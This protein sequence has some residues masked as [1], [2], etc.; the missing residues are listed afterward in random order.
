MLLNRRRQR[1]PDACLS[2]RRDGRRIDVEQ[3]KK[4]TLVALRHED[5]ARLFTLIGRSEFK[6]E[7]VQEMID[8][9]MPTNEDGTIN[10]I[11]LIA[12]HIHEEQLDRERRPRTKARVRDAD[13]QREPP[14][15][16]PH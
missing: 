14:R 6:P 2:Y 9:G 5:V 11:E 8:S 4:P 15:A 7:W 16:D 1:G 12:W 10:I 3:Q 13:D